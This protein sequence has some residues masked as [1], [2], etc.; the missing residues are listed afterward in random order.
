[1]ALTEHYSTANA[2]GRRTMD[3]QQWQDLKVAAAYFT[4]SSFVAMP[5]YEC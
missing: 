5:A 3:E 1:M 2:Y 4:S